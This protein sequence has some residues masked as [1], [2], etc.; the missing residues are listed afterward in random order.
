MDETLIKASL[1]E[2]GILKYDKM[3]P[4]VKGNSEVLI[5]AKKR[6]FM[7]QFLRELRNS[8]E[9]ILFTSGSRAYANAILREVIEENENFFDYV[10][11]RE[12]C[13]VDRRNGFTVKDLNLLMFNRKLKDIIIVD[14]C[15]RCYMK[16]LENGI[17]IPAYNGEENDKFLLLLKKYLLEKVFQ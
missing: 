15:S 6:P 13:L 3:L 12:H 2:K 17:P 1:C 14:N 9:L 5:Y 11:S 10:I 4:V 8:F 7:K 16:H